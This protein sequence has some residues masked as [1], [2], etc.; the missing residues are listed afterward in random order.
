MD[1]RKGRS[2]FFRQAEADNFNKFIDDS[3]LVDLP[4]C[5]RLFTWF[6]GDGVSMSRIDCF[7]LSSNWCQIWPNC[8]QVAYQRGVFPIMSR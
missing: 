7:L 3:F 2:A 5:G 1:E 4:I 8:I 6:K